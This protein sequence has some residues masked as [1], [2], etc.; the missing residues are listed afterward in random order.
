LVEG[1]ALRYA[2]IVAQLVFEHDNVVLGLA[3]MHFG[4]FVELEIVPDVRASEV[5]YV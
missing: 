5:I 4:V 2:G 3:G 1:A